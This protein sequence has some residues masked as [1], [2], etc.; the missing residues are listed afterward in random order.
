VTD[1]VGLV[2]RNTYIGDKLITWDARVSRALR[3]SERAKIELSFD[4]FNLLNRQNVD[5]VTS[6]YGSP[7]FFGAP[8]PQHFADGTGSPANPSFGSP[9]TMLNPRQLQFA[10]KLTF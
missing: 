5:E 1:R 10:A 8:V 6:V 4:A 7:D 9:R 3:L 2:R